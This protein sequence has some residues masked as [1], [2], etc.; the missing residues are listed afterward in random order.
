[1]GGAIPWLNIKDGSFL[2]PV[3]GD[4]R[5]RGYGVNTEAGVTV[6]PTPRVGVSVGYAY[7]VMWFDRASGASDR[8]FDL[9]PRFRE[10]SGSV[11]LSGL[12]TF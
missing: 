10:T 12:F 9:R 7:R 11:V 1:V 6:Y 2:D 5:F 4:A 8:L 3:V